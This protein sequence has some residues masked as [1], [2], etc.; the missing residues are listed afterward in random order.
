MAN[1]KEK[2]DRPK[3]YMTFWVD[4]HLMGINIAYLREINRHIDLTTVDLASPYVRGLMNLRGQIVTVLDLG[5]RLGLAPR[6][7]TKETGCIVLKS[8]KDLSVED[9]KIFKQPENENGYEGN[10]LIGLLVDK[11]A[12]I[13]PVE[14][15]QMESASTVKHNKVNARFLEYIVKLPKHLLVTLNINEIISVL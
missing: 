3:Q 11:I 4:E 15:N 14:P 7:M 10:D 1:I 13:L 2:E 6:K 8:I 9:Q 12:D 5:V